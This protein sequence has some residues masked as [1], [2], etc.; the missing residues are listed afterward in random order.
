MLFET[1]TV[2]GLA[3]QLQ[4]ASRVEVERIPRTPREGLPQCSFAQ[5]RLWFLEQLD[6]GQPTYHVPM[7]WR[8]S[9]VLDVAALDRSLA[10]LVERHESLR[11]TLVEIDGHPHQD[12]DPSI[13]FDLEVVDVPRA[14]RSTA[15][16]RHAPAAL[17]ARGRPAATRKPAAARGDRARA[18]AACSITS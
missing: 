17:L 10:A 15:S 1:P 9:G 14:P 4:N 3:E 2:A 7:A 5:E 12:I 13:A 18:S 8:L 6:P 11:T 16:S